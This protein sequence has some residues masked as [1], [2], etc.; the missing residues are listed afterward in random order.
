[1][2]VPEGALIK[3]PLAYP[4]ARRDAA[5]ATFVNTWIELKRKD[6]TLDRAVQVLD[7]RA[8]RRAETSAVGV[9]PRCAPL[10]AVTRGRASRYDFATALF[11]GAASWFARVALSMATT[12]SQTATS[13]TL[14]A[15]NAG[16]V[17]ISRS[18]PNTM[19]A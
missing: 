13:A 12:A 6:G 2:V 3:V 17:I 18:P 14:T 8:E 9:R 15:A 10:A 5:F 11:V 1:M 16:T 4:I 19:P 7:S